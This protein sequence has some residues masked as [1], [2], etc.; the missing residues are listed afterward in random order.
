MGKT[1]VLSSKIIEEDIKLSLKSIGF[2]FQNPRKILQMYSVGRCAKGFES[3]L[4][5]FVVY[6]LFSVSFR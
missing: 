4:L 3:M 6:E 5:F 2:A 1:P